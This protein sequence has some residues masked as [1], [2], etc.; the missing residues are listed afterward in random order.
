MAGTAVGHLKMAELAT[1]GQ[2]HQIVPTAIICTAFNFARGS[3]Q[4]HLQISLAQE[5]VGMPD[6]RK[7]TYLALMAKAGLD[8]EWLGE[9]M[10]VYSTPASASEN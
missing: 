7:Q 3:P 2:Y 8:T 6:F 9:E 10:G 1:I 4:Y 5:M